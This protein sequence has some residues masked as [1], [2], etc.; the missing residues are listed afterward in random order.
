MIIINTEIKIKLLEILVLNQIIE[1]QQLEQDLEI[2]INETER[3]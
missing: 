1:D 3:L 2:K